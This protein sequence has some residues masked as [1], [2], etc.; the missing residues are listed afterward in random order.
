MK[1]EI[2][3]WPAESNHPVTDKEDFDSVRLA[4][5]RAIFK[6]VYET[7]GDCILLSGGLDTSIVAAVVSARLGGSV[8]TRFKAY[9]VVLKG[10]PSPDLDFSKLISRKFLIPQKV[11]EV[12]L[13]ELEEY[14]P[15]VIS[16]LKSFDPMEVRNSVVAYI[17]MKEARKDGCFNVMTGD[18]SDE[19]F[20]GYSFVFKQDRQRGS[21]LCTPS[22]SKTP[23]LLRSERGISRK[24][25]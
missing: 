14:L 8:A 16:V 11:K 17:G 4:L 22:E 12:E 15:E 2:K 20:A 21:R 3:S 10:A 19:L 9:T 7:I 23:L 25:G 13:S 18:A 24:K 6:A 5:R 1:S